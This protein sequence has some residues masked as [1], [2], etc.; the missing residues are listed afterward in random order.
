MI[1]GSSLNWMLVRPGLLTNGDAPRPARVQVDYRRGM[2]VGSVS[3]LAV[4][5]FMVE[6][7]EQPGFLQRK[8]AL[9]AR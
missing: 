7:A 1:E 9:S 6:Q 5:R 3:R 2:K 8:P 4:A